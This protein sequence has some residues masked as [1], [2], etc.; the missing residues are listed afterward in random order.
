MPITVA[1]A[2]IS[3][4][5][6]LLVTKALLKRPDVYIRGSCRDIN[7]LPDEL[8]ASPRIAL[9]Q[10]GPYDREN[11]RALIGGSDVVMCAY[12]ADDETMLSAQRLL[13]D[14]CAEEGITRYIASD[15]TGDYRN[16]D[17]GD[18]AIKEPMKHIAAYV[19]EKEG[20][21]GIHILVGLFMETFLDYFGVVDKEGKKM[22]Y[23]G[24]GDEKWDLTSYETAAEYIAAVALD[25]AATG[26]FKF[27]GERKSARELAADVESVHGINLTMESRGFLTNLEAKLDRKGNAENIL[28]ASVYFILSGKT[29]LGEDVD[30]GRYP[31][32]TPERFSDFL[33]RYSR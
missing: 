20:V 10:S 15:Y 11:L 5:L 4:R 30:N 17:W 28:D 22:S 13:I 7:K 8:K 26:F 14:L 16:L 21:T 2:G 33:Q 12:F 23:W 27:R 3:S 25:P 31:E 6:A 24:S 9:I 1:I 32:V 18:L 29:G 19:E